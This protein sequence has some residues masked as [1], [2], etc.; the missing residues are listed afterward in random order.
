M[1][2]EYAK[3]NNIE[4]KDYN[5]YCNRDTWLVMLWLN[6]DQ[7][8]YEYIKSINVNNLSD[9]ELYEVLKNCY[10]RDSINFNKVDLDE[11]RA[12]LESEVK[13]DD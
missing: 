8:N 3:R 5:D 6:N 7:S 11:I 9:I 2:T 13:E 1:R 10:Y 4:F 12:N